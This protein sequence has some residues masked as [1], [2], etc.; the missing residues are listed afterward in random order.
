ML[1]PVVTRSDQLGIVS[2]VES[3]GEQEFSFPSVPGSTDCLQISVPESRQCFI[4][5]PILKS[6]QKNLE[7]NLSSSIDYFCIGKHHPAERCDLRFGSKR[8]EKF[9]IIFM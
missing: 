5:I 2:D 6:S 9:E 3:R 8:S 7:V 4:H 1:F